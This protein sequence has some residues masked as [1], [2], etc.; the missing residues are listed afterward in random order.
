MRL[1]VILVFPLVFFLA[2]LLSWPGSIAAA[3]VVDVADE[4]GRARSSA[5]AAEA[6]DALSQRARERPLIDAHLHYTGVDAA[7]LPPAAII[8]RFDANRIEAAV[9]SGQP[10]WPVEAL[11][12]AAPAR[13]LPFLSVYRGPAD[14]ERWMY[15]PDLPARAEEALDRGIYRGIGE[16]HLF[17]TDRESPVLAALVE[18]AEARDLV[19]QVHGDAEVIETIFARAPRVRVIWAHLGTDP[20]PQVVGEMLSRYPRLFVDTSVRDERFVDAEGCLWPQWRRFFIAHQDRVLVGVDTYW[21]PRW[22][23]FDE[24]VLR[25]RR[26][27]DQLPPEVADRLAYRNAAELFGIASP[28]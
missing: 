27:L 11:A 24:V 23:G 26:W 1:P 19:L 21:T 12:R 3:E 22:R 17:A 14:K 8:A 4:A 16:L 5:G 2:S 7:E 10:Q 15:D 18:L 25:L 20:R 9:V 13:I 28:E 6:C